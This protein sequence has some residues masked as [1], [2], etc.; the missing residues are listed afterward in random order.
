MSY[1]AVEG[2]TPNGRDARYRSLKFAAALVVSTIVMAFTLCGTSDAST[3]E[4][5]PSWLAPESFVLEGL[6]N[7]SLSRPIST[8]EVSDEIQNA[9]QQHAEWIASAEAEGEREESLD[10]YRDLGTDAVVDLI[11]DVFAEPLE[12]LTTLPTDPLLTSE[13][14]PRFNAGSD[15]SARIN[16]PGAED[17]RLITS[18]LPLRNSLGEIVSG[19]LQVEPNGFSPDAPLADVNFPERATGPVT[20]NDIQVS[21]EF[22]RTEGTAGR[23]VNA[24]E[25]SGKEMVI[26]PNTYPDTDT[27][28]IYT[29]TGVETFNYLR[30]SESPETFSLDYELPEGATIESTNDGGAVILDEDGNELASIFAPYA[31]DAQGSDVPM[32]LTVNGNQIILRVPHSEEDFAYPIMVDPVQHIRDWWTNGS[33]ANFAGWGFIQSGTSN[34]NHSQ[35]C[36]SALAS[37]DPCGGTGAGVYASAVPG[38]YY[39]AGSMG[40]W[41]WSVPGG[42]SSSITGVTLSSWRYRKGNSNPGWAFYNLWDSTSGH[43]FTEGGGG[44]GLSLTGANSGVKY[45]H[46]GL[47]TANA[48]T[49]PTGANNWRYARLAGFSASMTDG[50]APGLEMVEGPSGWLKDNTSFTVKA[51]ATDPGLGLGWIQAF[52]SGAWVNKWVGWCTGTYGAECPKSAAPVWTFNTSSFGNG[53]NSIPTRAIDIVSG[54]QHE[55]S[56]SIDFWVDKVSPTIGSIAPLT[57][58]SNTAV[59]GALHVTY[60]AADALSGVKNVQFSLDGNVISET[61]SGCEGTEVC[62]SAQE[63]F[64]DLSG[65]SAG[66]HTW[67]LQAF[68]GAGNA[69]T[70]KS[71]TLTLSPS[72]GDPDSMEDETLY[73][74]D[75]GQT[76][77]LGYF[78]IDDSVD[79]DQINEEFTPA[80][81]EEFALAVDPPNDPRVGTG[82]GAFH[83]GLDGPRH[84][85]I[86]NSYAFSY[87]VALCS[88]SHTRVFGVKVKT[89][90]E[91]KRDLLFGAADWPDAKCIEKSYTPSQA[92][93]RVRTTHIVHHCGNDDYRASNKLTIRVAWFPDPGAIYK[94]YTDHCD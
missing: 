38:S 31:V 94:S 68:D 26:Y 50:E 61:G 59:D 4:A 72:E 86:S 22:G 36:P 56:S 24:A 78:E 28:I 52:E 63:M 77:V 75:T 92:R 46:V 57:D 71:G 7:G 8:Q 54:S 17:S 11:T 87:S 9:K 2:A 48:N 33:S 44:S 51:D 19:E 20:F 15:T 81:T 79:L 70:A 84:L 62:E 67:S 85:G 69:S 23:L 66:S 65:Y 80:E 55:T 64:L 60:S 34:Y 16:P 6:D 73:E 35:T 18:D 53:A 91:R 37:I 29:L 21:F 58:G 1:V 32:S 25:G 12:A 13:D 27:A 40:Y 14:P 43:T 90:I 39:P 5:Q 10:A 47:A 93:A 88:G 42:S 41:R 82:F 89:C 76:G 3:G 74:I 45:L 30:S 49:M 83:C